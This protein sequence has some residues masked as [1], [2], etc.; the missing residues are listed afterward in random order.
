M[1]RLTVPFLKNVLPPVSRR[2]WRS[3]GRFALLI[4]AGVWLAPARAAEASA[5]LDSWLASQTNLV[6]WQAAFTQ[7]RVL[8]TLNQ[9]LTTQGRIWFVA[10]NRFR[11][12]LG[13][14]P[15]TIA[16]RQAADMLI[17]YPRLK[18][19]ERYS[20]DAAAL[21]PWKDA[22]ALLD[23]GFPRSRA[24]LDAAFTIGGVS[25]TNG[26]HTATLRPKSATARKIMPEVQLTFSTADQTLRATQ[27][28]F[29]D[30]S[31]MRNDFAQIVTNAVIA[32]DVFR[33]EIPADY[34][35]SQ[36]VN[37]KARR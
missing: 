8:S 32:G 22:V 13:D 3:A 2:Q 12:E 35:I 11:W 27:L 30:G 14:P 24:D 9:P 10:P 34:E 16:V 4:L 33:P 5:A 15:Q 29:A 23:T 25:E 6:S 36:P 28:R 17:V 18:R 20:L 21:G 7:T 31:M 1:K 37:K 26:L 19:A